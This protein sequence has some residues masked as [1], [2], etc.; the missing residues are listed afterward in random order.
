[1]HPSQP[2]LRVRA[3][4]LFLIITVLAFSSPL[5]RAQVYN[6][7]GDAGSTQGGAQNT[8]FNIGPAGGQWT[9]FGTIGPTN[10]NDADVYQ[11]VLNAPFTF[12]ATTVN[13]LTAASGGIGGLDTQLFLF[14]SAGVPIYANNDANGTTL[15]ST[16]PS[17]SNFTFSLGAGVY[18]LAI[19]LSG[20]DPVNSNGQLV[21]ATGGGDP[22]AIRGIASGINP[23]NW[24]D[25][26]NF[27]SVP[28]TGAYQINIFSAPESGS[29]IVMMVIALAAVAVARRRL[30]A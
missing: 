20:N 22:T 26:D 16:L 27:T 18:Y 7:S 5:L 10:A 24:N 28:Q 25:F 23:T 3:L 9:I 30:A 17:R 21:F 15:Q 1:M 8:G 13:P 2:S 19:S 12:S 14:N 4:R 11:L 6:E 29:T